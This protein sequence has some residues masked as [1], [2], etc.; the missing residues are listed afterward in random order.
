M[1]TSKCLVP[2]RHAHRSVV[3]FSVPR[4][5]ARSS[6]PQG[7]IL[8]KKSHI[9]RNCKYGC[10]WNPIFLPFDTPIDPLC[11]LVY[12]VL[13]LDLAYHREPSQ[14]KNLPLVEIANMAAYMEANFLAL[15]VTEIV[16]RGAM[17][18]VMFGAVPA[19]SS[20]RCAI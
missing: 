2:C 16:Y 11:F 1:S 5:F 13:L 3:L 19:R 20:I 9:S 10:L 12:H 17:I 6:L 15:W 7:T 18:N 8:A 4:A 14:Q